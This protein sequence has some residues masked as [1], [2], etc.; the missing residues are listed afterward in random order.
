[1]KWLAAP[2]LMLAAGAASAA[3][4]SHDAEAGHGDRAMAG[5]ADP[6]RARQN[7]ILQCQGCHRPDATGTP[8]TTPAM[9]GFVARFLSVPGGRDYLARVPGVATAALSDA[10]LADVLN[11]S[12]AR[13]DP[14]HVPADFE[15][16]TA[17]EI[18]RLRQNPLRTEANSARARLIAR[19]DETKIAKTGKDVR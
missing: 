14:A 10:A 13:F 3:S 5:V 7:W 15:P 9:A 1:M 11:W 2:A 12:L 19:F 17:A 6:A 8:Q 4:T 18:G 16:Y